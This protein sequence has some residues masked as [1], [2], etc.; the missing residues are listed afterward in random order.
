MK[1][2]KLSAKMCTEMRIIM[3]EFKPVVFKLGDR[4]FGIDITKIQGIEKEQQIVPVP[5]TEEY[6]IGIMNLRGD[7]WLLP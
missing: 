7:V 2:M 5:N 1:T 4:K 6:I 3:E